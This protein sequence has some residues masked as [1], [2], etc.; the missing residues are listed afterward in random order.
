MQHVFGGTLICDGTMLSTDSLCTVDKDAASQLAFDK[1]I[2]TRTVTVEGDVYEPSGTM[3]GGSAPRAGSILAKL[4]QHRDSKA[5]LFALQQKLAE[6][7]KR[8][9]AIAEQRSIRDAL[10]QKLELATH[11]LQ[12]QQRQFELDPMG[13]TINRIEAIKREIDSLERHVGEQSAIKSSLDRQLKEV[14]K[15]MQDFMG[16]R[17]GKLQAIQVRWQF[18]GVLES[19]GGKQGGPFEGNRQAHKDTARNADGASR[20]R[21]S[22]GCAVQAGG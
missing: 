1:K 4:S 12:A 21:P 10:K 15:D 5:E 14:E 19:V 2:L 18:H 3:T 13:K 6:V 22:A 9:D 16:D 8:L 11:E 20:S 17:E 7:A